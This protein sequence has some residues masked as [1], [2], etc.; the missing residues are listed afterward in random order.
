MPGVGVGDRAPAAVDVVQ[1]VAVVVSGARPGPARPGTSGSVGVLD[2]QRRRVDADAGDAAVEPEPQDVLVLAAHVGVVPVEVGLLGR[3][4]VQVPLA[5]R[6]VGVRRA[7]PGRARE[8]RDPVRSASRRRPRPCRGGTRSAPAPGEPGPAASAAWNQGCWS[9]TWLGTTS[10]IVRMPS[11]QRLGDERL[12]LGE[13]AEAR[14]DGAVV[15][16]VVAAVGER[17][18]TYQGV[19]QIASTPRSRR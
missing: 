10:T 9:E 5:G 1:L 17:A 15:G 8:V 11:A 12:G 4:Q 3:E 7:G 2:Q 19:N 16:D 18:T 6:A 14:V 13:R